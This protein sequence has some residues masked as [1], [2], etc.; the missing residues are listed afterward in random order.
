MPGETT[1][2]VG[3]HE[4][5]R[6]SI[7]EG[8][9]SLAMQRPASKPQ[10][11]YGPT[12]LFGYTAET[13][14]LP[15]GRRR[16]WILLSTPILLYA[17]YRIFVPPADAGPV[18]LLGWLVVFYLFLQLFHVRFKRTSANPLQFTK[19]SFHPLIHLT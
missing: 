2:C 12:R 6:A 16:P 15:L 9:Q 3:C 7:P 8:L 10:P 11:W 19:H 13:V 18:Y 17:V 1:G 14:R 4:N 5:R